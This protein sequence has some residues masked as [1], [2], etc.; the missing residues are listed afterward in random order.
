[1]VIGWSEIQVRER[2]AILL[3]PLLTCVFGHLI[4]VSFYNSIK[5]A[6][7]GLEVNYFNGIPSTF[8]Y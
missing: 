1:M 4:H 2:S 5:N 8:I 6:E 7:T 3:A